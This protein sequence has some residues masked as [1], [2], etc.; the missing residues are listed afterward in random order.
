MS[1]ICLSSSERLGQAVAMEP[2]GI[3]I[4]LQPIVIQKSFLEAYQ[5][6]AILPLTL[7]NNP[8][9]LW[10]KAANIFC[11][12]SSGTNNEIELWEQLISK[13]LPE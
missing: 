9:S 5:G 1:S 8:E 10:Y 13:S 6:T 3:A 4:R 12:N 7:T 2:G 11:S